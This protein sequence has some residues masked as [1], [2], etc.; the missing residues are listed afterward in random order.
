MILLDTSVW[1][2]YYHCLPLR[3]PLIQ[4]I[5][6]ADELL[7]CSIS[8]WEVATK[9]RHGKL[10]VPPMAQW[11]EEAL[12]DY[13]VLPITAEIAREAGSDSMA[14]QDPADRLIVATARIH[15]LELVHTD[16]KLRRLTTIRHRYFKNVQ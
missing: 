1:L 13:I 5:E 11:I 8:V 4:V 3:K 6:T 15:D 2:R 12:A 14:N 7:L 10:Q 9:I 16:T